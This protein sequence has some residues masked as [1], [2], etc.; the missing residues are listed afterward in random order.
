MGVGLFLIVCLSTFRLDEVGWTFFNKTGVVVP[1]TENAVGVVGLYVAAV[2]YWIFGCVAWL[3]A[4]AFEWL[5]LYRVLFGDQNDN[6]MVNAAYTLIGSACVAMAVQ[7]WIG[8]EWGAAHSSYGIGGAL[9]HGLGEV[10]IQRFL[11]LYP[12]LSLA[13]V[14]Y[15]VALIY[16][17]GLT[18]MYFVRRLQDDAYEYVRNRS[19]RKKA[20][21]MEEISAKNNS[22]AELTPR[23]RKNR[24]SDK[25][26]M[27]PREQAPRT[28]DSL[29]SLWDDG[30]EGIEEEKPK[31]EP[32]TQSEQ[33]ELPRQ[34]KA[35]E[36]H[37]STHQSAKGRVVGDKPF[38][39]SFS[40]APDEMKRYELPGYGLLAK[41]ERPKE[42][43]AEEC[44][45]LLN[46]QNVIVDTLKSF[47]VDVTAGNITKGPTITRYEIYPSMG[48]RVNKITALE[49]DIARAA[50]AVRI[51]IL[52]PIPGK[53][54]VGIEIANAKK[55]PVCL[56]ELLEDPQFSAPGKRIPL[57]LGK[58]VYGNT[59]IG[60]LAAMP[61]LL[62]A[63]TTGSGKSV[64]I[65]SIITSI[66]YKFRPDELRFILVDPKVVEMQPYAK[67]PHL[68]IP[69]VT[70]PKKVV[71][72]LRW[73]VNE[74]ERRYHIFAK[75]GVRNFEAFNKRPKDMPLEDE[76]EEEEDDVVDNDVIEQM[77]RDFESQGE[78]PEEIEDDEFEDDVDEIPDRFPYIVIII[79]ELADLM[80]T[81]SA[82]VE[83]YIGRLTQKARAAGI[84]LI[85]ATQTPRSDVVTGI[86]KANIP[87]RIAFQVATAL[88]SRIILDQGGAEKLVGK[89]DLLYLPPGSAELQR[90]QGAF[91][92]D[93]E[94][95]SLV[96]HCAKQA[97][98]RF[99]TEVQAEVDSSGDTEDNGSDVDSADEELFERCVEVVRVD[100]KASTSLLQRRLKI[101]YGK[102]A[103]MIDLM[104]QRKVISPSDGSSRAR[105]VL[106]PK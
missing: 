29:E 87:C 52:A 12:T 5:G 6:K 92:S 48:L 33:Q 58:D 24:F 99:L 98:Q 20:R 13:C 51:N 75:V 43:S 70:E 25:T 80:Q 1:G 74:M 77:A 23:P 22:S 96:K 28:G 97:K 41:D 101:G 9:G 17:F 93:D 69:V 16:F 37:D 50:K 10:L 44:K 34:V 66:L 3:V 81:A 67:L 39:T 31:K 103:R 78:D 102:A 105:E 54:T 47:G 65:N 83:T 40:P 26:P 106:L 18:P 57:A 46:T 64:C 27:E 19:E 14:V 32:R 73:C 62:V 2:L 79:D 85:V 72:A 55:V 4:I 91:I 60:D 53:D 82:D 8:A 104:E 15:L 21:I 90:A 95:E 94:V 42:Q 100:R 68:I 30:S 11:G 89:G 38:T 45:E 61:H 59:V 56:R 63:G 71:G 7:P 88:D 49:K 86:I 84:H 36:I 76:D 35:P